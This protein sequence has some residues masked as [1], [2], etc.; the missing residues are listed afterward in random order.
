MRTQKASGIIFGLPELKTH[1]N[2]ARK[3]ILFDFDIVHHREFVKTS[4]SLCGFPYFARPCPTNPRHGFVDSRVI[5]NKTDLNDLLIETKNADEHGEL[6][7]CKPINA[8]Y[9]AIFVD[10][11]YLSIGPGNDGATGGKGSVALPVAP[12]TIPNSILKSS[13]LNSDDYVYIEAVSDSHT[14]RYLTQLRG[15]PYIQ[16]LSQDFIPKDIVIKKVI[17]PIDN[18]LQWESLVKT[19]APGTVVYGNGHTL[20]SHAA[21]HCIINN[22]PFITSFEP[23]LGTKLKKT[24]VNKVKF[25]VPLFKKGVRVGLNLKLRTD[26]PGAKNYLAF[27][28]SVLHNWSYIQSTHHA[29]W[30]LG[31]ATTILVRYCSALAH[32]EHEYLYDSDGPKVRCLSLNQSKLN[33]SINKLPDIIR[34]FYKEEWDDGFGGIP[35]A[36]CSW[37][38]YNL[39]SQITKLYNKYY[40]SKKEINN[41]ISTFNTIV[42][43]AH[44]NCWWLDKLVPKALFDLSAA[45]P[46]VVAF[47]SFPIIGQIYNQL[48]NTKSVRLKPIRRIKAPFYV[49]KDGDVVWYFVKKTNKGCDLKFYSYNVKSR[50]TT[51]LNINLFEKE[52]G[53]I[54]DKLLRFKS[55]RFRPAVLP[56]VGNKLSFF[57]V[58]KVPISHVNA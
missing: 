52:L 3:R 48:N 2:L 16:K 43:L 56:I 54:S 29:S 27:V 4:D 35:W 46:G 1:L 37:Y 36:T 13:K 39:W 5:H 28:F 21:I 12:I 26:A 20:A 6:L 58:R 11:G 34:D 44:N 55:T 9:N 22:V 38:T 23:K 53:I 57:G 32:D 50:R 33:L 25:S 18:L 30:L 19:L 47:Y 17:K 14:E 42:N 49:S 51:K 15:G 41:L 10:S 45:K 40:F 7:I 8:K 24:E 31:A